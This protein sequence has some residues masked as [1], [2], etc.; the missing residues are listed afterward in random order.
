MDKR[1]FGIGEPLI[2]R[3]RDQG[4]DAAAYLDLVKGLGCNAFRSWMHLTEVLKDPA[5][6]DEK[7]VEEHTRLLDRAKEL[8][9][10]VTGMSHEWFLPEGCIQRTGHAM[11]KRSFQEGSLY[12]QTLS[13]LEESWYTMARTFPQ[14][15]IWEVGNEWN[16]NAFL[17]PD[18]F[19]GTDMSEPFTADEK[20]DIAVDM[21]YFSAKG[22][23]RAGTGA[24]VASFSPALSTPGLGGDMP[25]FLPV[26]YGV[27]W[28]FDKIYSR[29][30]SGRFWS[31]DPDDYFDIVSW[32]PYVFTNRETQSDAD[33]F[34]NVDEPDSLWRSFN[35]AA[36]KVM[37]KY[38][39]GHKQVILTETGFT[40]LGDPELEE[41]YAR[42]NKKLLEIASELPYVRTLHNFRLLNENAMLKRA[43]IE[44]NQI[45][46]LTEVYFGV[47]TDPADGCRPRKRAFAIQEM[48]GAK[49]D[50]ETLGRKLCLDQEGKTCRN[51][52]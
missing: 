33:L 51:I 17:H 7:A 18:G 4:I 16:L 14:V 25:D 26:M 39:D 15:S 21:M 43:G 24:K 27:A 49:E 46:G 35:D 30:R 22:I 31:D 6:P 12:M 9:I 37:K 52:S 32:H 20:M 5:T 41:K 45:G 19:L 36:Y 29:I 10:E 48:T 2:Q 23:R 1:F 47:F 13:M 44:D 11:P 42:Y 8:D 34:L 3:Q 50:L 38:G 28:T 40:D